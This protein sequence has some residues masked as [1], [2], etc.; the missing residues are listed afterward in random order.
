MNLLLHPAFRELIKV[1][2]C[3]FARMAHLRNTFFQIIFVLV[4]SAFALTAPLNATSEYSLATI[5]SIWYRAVLEIIGLLW[6]LV[7]IGEVGIIII[8]F[9]VFVVFIKF[10]FLTKEFSIYLPLQGAVKWQLF[11]YIFF[12]SGIL[13]IIY[14]I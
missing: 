9:V 11:Q 4:W 3:Y 5:K 8:F 13:S 1:K 6:T 7:Y 14:S 10:I 2:W 12:F